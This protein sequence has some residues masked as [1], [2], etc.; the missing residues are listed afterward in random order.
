MSIRSRIRVSRSVDP[1]SGT[2]A[3]AIRRPEARG[4][5]RRARAQRRGAARAAEAAGLGEVGEHA[6]DVA[7]ADQHLPRLGALVAGDDAAPLEHVDQ[8]AGAGVAEPQAPLQHRRR[9]GLHLGHEPDRV[10]EQRVVV[11][12][13]VGIATAAGLGGSSSTSSSSS[14]WNSGSP[15]RRQ[16]LGE[17][18]D[19]RLVDVGALDALQPRRADGREEHVALPEQ[20]LGAVLVEDHA[21]VGLGGHGEGDPRRHVGLDHAGDDVHARGL[22]GEHEVD[23]DR[24]RLL[25]DADDRVLDVGRRDHHQVGELVDDAEDVR[26]RR[27]AAARRG[28]C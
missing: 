13:E 11:R 5:V 20:R 24:A 10:L 2:V 14:S 15:W 27:L 21:R 26:Q 3:E 19:L 6:R 22:G 28:P 23:A 25:G 1:M 9:R 7:L 4:R 16:R 8:P 12:V 18:E 17:L